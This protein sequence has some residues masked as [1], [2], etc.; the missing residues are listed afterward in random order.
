M[1]FLDA[2]QLNRSESQTVPA[3]CQAII[4]KTPLRK[5]LS[6]VA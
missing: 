3:F 6:P 2:A 4:T 5:P 1:L